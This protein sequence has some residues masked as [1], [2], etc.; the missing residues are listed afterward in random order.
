MWAPGTAPNV[1]VWEVAVALQWTSA[2]SVG[3]PELDA[4]QQELFRR[5][6]R[7]LDA[8]LHADRSEAGRLL[9]FLHEYALGHFAAEERLLAE[10]D[11]PDADVHVLEHRHF[12]ATLQELERSLE[13]SGATATLVLQLQHQCVGWLRDHVYVTDVALG[14]AVRARQ[15]SA[16]ARAAC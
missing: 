14:R 7:L 9:A 3:V 1:A 16:R 4:D 2:L 12:S 10:V 13:A 6:D 8:M 11:C 5:I 15:V